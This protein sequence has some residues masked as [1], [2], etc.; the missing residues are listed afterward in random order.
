MKT[1]QLPALGYEVKLLG[2]SQ[3]DEVMG[4]GCMVVGI[5]IG[6]YINR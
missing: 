2:S 1:H 5:I 6:T 3:L 4:H